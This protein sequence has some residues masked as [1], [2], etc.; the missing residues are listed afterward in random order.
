MSQFWTSFSSTMHQA[1]VSI[2]APRQQTRKYRCKIILIAHN[3]RVGV[4]TVPKSEIWIY[5]LGD[6]LRVVMNGCYTRSRQIISRMLQS[7]R[8]EDA[9]NGWHHMPICTNTMRWS[10]AMSLSLA[11]EWTAWCSARAARL[12]FILPSLQKF[13]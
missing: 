12:E 6:R 2:L 3:N 9:Q 4:T 1:V 11:N 10:K 5:L 13:L 8:W 7:T